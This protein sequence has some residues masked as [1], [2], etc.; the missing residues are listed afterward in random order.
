M[1][2]FIVVIGGFYIEILCEKMIFMFQFDLYF[3]ISLFNSILKKQM[4]F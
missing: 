2:L 1:F 3:K 4:K